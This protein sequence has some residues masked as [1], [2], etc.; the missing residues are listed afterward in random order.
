MVSDYIPCKHDL[1]QGPFRS[2]MTSD[3]IQCKSVW[4]YLSQEHVRSTMTW[5]YIPYKLDLAQRPFRSKMTSDH[6]Q[7][8]S[9]WHYLAQGHVRS[10]MTWDYIHVNR[11]GMI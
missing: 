4:H 6:I 3:H 8:K 9:V 1:A 5:D 7:C 10:T 11:L 2:K